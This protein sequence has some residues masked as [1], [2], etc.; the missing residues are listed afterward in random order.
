[1][2]KKPIP[3][4]PTLLFQFWAWIMLSLYFQMVMNSSRTTKRNSSRKQFH[5][6]QT[7]SK[8]VACLATYTHIGEHSHTNSAKLAPHNVWSK[9]TRLSHLKNWLRAGIPP[10]IWHMWVC[11]RIYDDILFAGARRAPDR[12]CASP[13][14]TLPIDF[15]PSSSPTS[16][17]GMPWPFT[18][19]S[20]H[21]LEH[22]P[23]SV[24]IFHSS[25]CRY[26]LPVPARSCV[27]IKWK[28]IP[29]AHCAWNVQRVF[30]FR[31]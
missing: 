31:W 9:R 20:P 25:F 10:I 22:A 8:I 7:A 2:Q 17:A 30:G 24:R 15:L 26:A 5:T 14:L 6:N 4:P 27:Y 19:R 1:M 16:L 12:V 11:V 21:A 13:A 18:A 28:C 23:A 29:S 3:E